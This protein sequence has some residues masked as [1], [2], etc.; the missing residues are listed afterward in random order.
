MKFQCR[1]LV[2][3]YHALKIYCVGVAVGHKRTVFSKGLVSDSVQFFIRGAV[4]IVLKREN[5]L[6]LLGG[7]SFSFCESNAIPLPLPL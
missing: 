2:N 4:G 5:R 6:I 7:L 1:V 3:T